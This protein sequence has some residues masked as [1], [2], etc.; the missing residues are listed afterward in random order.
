MFNKSTTDSELWHAISSGNVHAFDT[1]VE[2]YWEAVYTTAFSYLKD[3]DAS[4]EIASD[5]FLSI[6]QKRDSLH[7]NT[8]KSYLTASAR[9]HVYK[10]LKA[11]STLRLVYVEDYEPLCVTAT[12]E[13]EGEE[14]IRYL[15]LQSDIENALQELAPRCREIFLMSRLGNLSNTEIAEKL[16][17]SKRTV[18]NQISIAQKFLQRNSKD[19][20]LAFLLALL[21]R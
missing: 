15:N 3:R 4:T 5:T 21:A 7:I 13:N 8:F 20:A 14:K 6:W 12:V 9:Y 17:I 10:I 1:L 16:S 11:K 19:I 2:R 18:E